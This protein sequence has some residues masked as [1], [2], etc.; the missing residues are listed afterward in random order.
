LSS[1]GAPGVGHDWQLGF[2]WYLPLMTSTAH[3]TREKLMR[4]KVLQRGSRGKKAESLTRC[5]S[6]RQQA[7]RKLVPTP[8]T[9]AAAGSW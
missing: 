5:H 7:P 1:T 8:R 4:Q 3:S 9:P 6:A 2:F